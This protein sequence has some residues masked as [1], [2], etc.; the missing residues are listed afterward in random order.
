MSKIS[1]YRFNLFKPNIIMEVEGVIFDL[2]NVLIS[3]PFDKVMELKGK[4]FQNILEKTNTPIRR[5]ELIKAWSDANKSVDYAFISHFYQETP[6]IIKALT[7]LKLSKEKA[8]E[9]AF[10]LLPAYRDG[11]RIVIKNDKIGSEAKEVLDFLKSKNKKLAI[12][13]CE[14][15]NAVR[16]MIKWAGLDKYFDKIIISEETGIETNSLTAFRYVLNSLGTRV[17]GTVYVGLKKE[18]EMAKMA[19]LKTIMITNKK[20]EFKVENKPDFIISKIS[21]IKNII[22]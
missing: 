17:S 6:I 16:T 19:G 20:Q 1:K 12:L 21:E 13:S 22:S 10:Q 11:L 2:S 8:E 3:D 15:A 7:N 14:N 9:L 5:D 4:E 18:I